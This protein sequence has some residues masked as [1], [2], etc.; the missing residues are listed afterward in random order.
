MLLYLASWKLSFS[1]PLKRS[2]IKLI[3]F[4]ACVSAQLTHTLSSMDVRHIKF[5]PSATYICFF[6]DLKVS[7]H[8]PFIERTHKICFDRFYQLFLT[9]R[10]LLQPVSADILA[11]WIRTVM[12]DSGI[13]TE[14]FGAHSVRGA[15]ASFA[16]QKLHQLIVLYRLETGLAYRL[17]SSITIESTDLFLQKNCQQQLLRAIFF[18]SLN[19]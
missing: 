13:N 11:S 12:L 10:P 14:A 1:S 9:W 15:S 3:T 17:L 2:T 4:L 7:R 6:A 18:D 5:Y 19:A 8:R 16:L